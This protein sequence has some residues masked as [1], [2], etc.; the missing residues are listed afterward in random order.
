MQYRK[1]IRVLPIA[2]FLL[3]F[4]AGQ[5]LP[6]SISLKNGITL[7]YITAGSGPIPIIFIHGYSFSADAWEK[8]LARLPGRYAGYAYDLR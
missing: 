7:R 1:I 3:V 6:D 5:A 4:T 2:L 8:V